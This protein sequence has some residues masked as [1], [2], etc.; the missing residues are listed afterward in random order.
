MIFVLQPFLLQKDSKMPFLIFMVVFIQKKQQ[1][2]LICEKI[3]ISSVVVVCE[4]N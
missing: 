1:R 3:N 2:I 4:T